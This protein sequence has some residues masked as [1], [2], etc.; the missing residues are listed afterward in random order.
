V[1]RTSSSARVVDGRRANSAV[2]YVV[3]DAPDAG[4]DLIGTQAGTV[5]FAHANRRGAATSRIVLCST[6]HHDHR[7]F[8]RIAG[9]A[10]IS[11]IH[12]LVLR[13]L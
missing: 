3:E 2:H 1:S 7:A 8:N 4:T 11:D 6:R 9:M 10:K 5:I 12:E 13:P